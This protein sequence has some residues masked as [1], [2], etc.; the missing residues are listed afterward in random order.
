MG[1]IGDWQGDFQRLAQSEA[2]GFLTDMA[3]VLS[4][5]EQGKTVIEWNS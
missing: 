1:I 2:E 5:I 4:D 3:D